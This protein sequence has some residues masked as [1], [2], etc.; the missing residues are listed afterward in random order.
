MR[1]WN[2][3]PLIQRTN[4]IVRID[5]LW[6][7]IYLISISIF[8][9]C[10]GLA[11][12]LHRRE[13]KTDRPARVAKATRNGGQHGV[14]K[15]TSK[16]RIP[17]IN[18]TCQNLAGT[19]RLKLTTHGGGRMSTVTLHSYAW[20]ACFLYGG[21]RPGPWISWLATAVWGIFL[22]N[23]CY[24]DLKLINCRSRKSCWWVTFWPVADLGGTEKN[25]KFGRL[26]IPQ[27]DITGANH[28]NAVWQ[29]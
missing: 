5:V 16:P 23:S 18:T 3:N 29:F 27:D 14:R 24:C 12:H 20:S 11:L 22:F 19:D 17:K 10:D 15:K 8:L 25:H 26:Y 6:F 7:S 28:Y 9:H 1:N 2:P 13:T 4:L 21:S